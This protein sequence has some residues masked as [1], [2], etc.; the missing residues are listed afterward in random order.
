MEYTTGQIEAIQSIQTWYKNGSKDN[1]YRLFGY[2]GTGKTTVVSAVIKELKIPINRIAFLTPTNK[3]RLVLENR[4][5]DPSNDN[6]FFP[7]TC[8]TAHRALYSS[9][10]KKEAAFIVS[11]LNAL[12]ISVSKEEIL[13]SNA[14]LIKKQIKELESQYNSIKEPWVRT[15]NSS[16][17]SLNDDIDDIERQVYGSKRIESTPLY[18]KRLIVVDEVSMLAY[19]DSFEI[20]AWDIPV[21]A[22]GDPA[23]LPPVPEKNNQTYGNFFIPSNCE[24]KADFLL[25]EITRNKEKSDIVLLSKCLRDSGSRTLFNMKKSSGKTFGEVSFDKPISKENFKA[26]TSIHLVSKHTTRIKANNDIRKMLGHD[27]EWDFIP[28]PGEILLCQKTHYKEM[29]ITHK[30]GSI[31]KQRVT[32]LN[33]GGLYT[34]LGYKDTN[35]KEL[36]THEDVLTSANRNKDGIV[37][38]FLKDSF[39]PNDEKIIEFDFSPLAFRIKYTSGGSSAARASKYYLDFGYAIT[40]HSAQGSE[41]D[42]VTI[43]VEYMG[44]SPD[45]KK[46]HYTAVTRAKKSLNIVYPKGGF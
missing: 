5:S 11:Q 20:M 7:H 14:D 2:A 9:I 30:D 13:G 44:E 29:D 6:S 1:L 17:P 12:K 37:K 41:F 24:V 39:M 35:N 8:V 43:I 21:I 26:E 40:I 32:V 33:N 28:A 3:A 18:G 36:I 45:Y 23:Q 38:L 19:S 46:V 22:I 34:V 42:N 31:E 10:L 4:L 25:T 15:V 27:V 16:L